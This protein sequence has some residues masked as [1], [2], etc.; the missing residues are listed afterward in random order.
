MAQVKIQASKNGP[1]L[2]NGEVEI[3]DSEGKS[4]PPK[5]SVALCRCG[6]SAGKPFCDGSHRKVN[7]QG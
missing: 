1:L 7:F 2:V 4:L 3:V 5:P 6:H